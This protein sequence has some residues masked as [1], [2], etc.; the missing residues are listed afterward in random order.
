VTRL[1]VVADDSLIVE[2]ITIGLRRSAEFKVLGHVNG[3]AASTRT[4]LEAAPDVVLVDDMGQSV[5]AVDIIRA[6]KGQDERVAAIVLTLSM[7]A[8]WL[9]AIFDAGATGAISKAA[10]PEALSTLVRETVSGHVVHL[11]RRPDSGRD[12]RMRAMVVHDASLTGREIEVLQ[13]VAAGSTNGQI[14]RRLWVTEQT[15]KFHLANVYRKLGVGNRTEA[16]RYAHVNGL[17]DTRQ[18]AEIA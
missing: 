4:V 11:Y 7:D 3:C 5:H 10:H 17:L 18:P 13:L 6:I 12:S 14:A 1:V 2:A 9:D 8:D 15:V 16:S